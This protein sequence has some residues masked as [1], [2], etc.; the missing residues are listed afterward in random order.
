MLA[1]LRL[2][3]HI[4]PVLE[5]ICFIL[6][7]IILIL[8]LITQPAFVWLGF[9][10]ERRP[11][12][13][14][15]RILSLSTNSSIPLAVLAVT[16]TFLLLSRRNAAKLSIYECLSN[17]VL[18]SAVRERRSFQV[19]PTEAVQLST[20]KAT[21]MNFRT[22]TIVAAILTVLVQEATEGAETPL[23]AR[24]ASSLLFLTGR[25]VCRD[26]VHALAVFLSHFLYRQRNV[27]FEVMDGKRQVGP[28]LGVRR[29]HHAG[30][31]SEWCT[32]L[33]GT[34]TMRTMGFHHD[35]H[36]D[37]GDRNQLDIVPS[38]APT[39]AFQIDG[40]TLRVA[41]GGQIHRDQLRP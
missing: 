28:R 11:T 4:G 37:M 6:L 31:G 36:Q 41:L 18:G 20:A 26:H 40:Q 16:I 9:R 3:L 10:C 7:V 2:Q 5:F 24:L 27:G 39:I 1:L 32:S 13:I 22:V 38:L 15:I 29:P 25:F 14:S 17:S 12:S 21:R 33:P 34:T 23:L 19:V 35:R 8:A 30:H